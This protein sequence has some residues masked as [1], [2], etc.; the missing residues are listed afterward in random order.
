MNK[1]GQ[2]RFRSLKPWFQTT[3]A[4]LIGVSA[5]SMS[6]ESNAAA[7]VPGQSPVT[8]KKVTVRGVVIDENSQPVPGVAVLV[9]GK[10]SEGGTMTDQNGEFSLAVPADAV[11]QFSCIGYKPEERPVAQTT[12]W[13]VT[14]VE[15]WHWKVQSLS[16]MVSR[17]RKASWEPLRRLNPRNWTRLELPALPMRWP[18]KFRDSLFFPRVAAREK[19]TRHCLSVAFPAGMETRLWS[20]STALNVI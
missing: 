2:S 10:P 6:V 14:L 1:S 18:E 4:V 15:E 13:L 5:L 19:M 12:D 11:V 20:W 16:V 8:P 17:E 3:L 9:K 7:S